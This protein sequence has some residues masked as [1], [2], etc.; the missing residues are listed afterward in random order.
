MQTL[1]IDRRWIDLCGRYIVEFQLN[2][3]GGGAHR[4]A[5]QRI[6]G[7]RFKS[8]S[9]L[10]QS[11]PRT[12]TLD[13]E[14]L[15]GT[16]VQIEQGAAVEERHGCR[17]DALGSHR[18][19]SGIYLVRLHDDGR[20]HKVGQYPPR[21]FRPLTTAQALGFPSAAHNGA[22]RTESLRAAMATARARRRTRSAW[23]LRRR[24]TALSPC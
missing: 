9:I 11:T 8:A 24:G 3:I 6:A 7:E 14:R 22:S 4:C 19:R 13:Q 17:Y 2:F 10:R 20:R 15:A 16:C 5:G 23:P 12:A 21:P 1:R 18:C